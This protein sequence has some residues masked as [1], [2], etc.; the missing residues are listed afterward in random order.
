MLKFDVSV[1]RRLVWFQKCQFLWYPKTLIFQLYIA[2][3]EIFK[4]LAIF[5]QLSQR[6]EIF[7]G[8]SLGPY[9]AM[10]SLLKSFINFERIGHTLIPIAVHA[11]MM[12]HRKIWSL[13]N[14]VGTIVKLGLEVCIAGSHP[15]DPCSIPGAGSILYNILNNIK[16]NCTSFGLNCCNVHKNI[17]NIKDW[18]F[19]SKT[20][21]ITKIALNLAQI[22][23]ISLEILK[24]ELALK[25]L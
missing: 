14:T 24:I 5:V 1:T 9:A 20:I 4:R 13:S 2:P 6:A 23:I 15:A 8:S 17:N 10:V 18:N 12:C 22:V 7:F 19:Q 21:K 16:C 25:V 3:I 11:R